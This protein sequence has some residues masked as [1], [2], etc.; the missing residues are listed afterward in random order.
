MGRK[1]KRA[2]SVCDSVGESDKPDASTTLC[3]GPFGK[4]RVDEVRGRGLRVGRIVVERDAEQLTGLRHYGERGPGGV[5]G[6]GAS[7]L[8]TNARRFKSTI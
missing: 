6:F 7:K 3:R 2:Y 8:Y 4:E 1:E 5:G